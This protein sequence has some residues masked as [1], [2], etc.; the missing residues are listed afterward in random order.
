M[1]LGTTVKATSARGT[2]V[3]GRFA[4]EDFD[5]RGGKWIKVNVAPKGKPA[6]IKKYRPKAV[7]KAE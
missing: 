7:V 1:K 3:E 4:G 2:V 6:V 5:V